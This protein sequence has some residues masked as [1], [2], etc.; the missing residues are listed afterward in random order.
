MKTTMITLALLAL[1]LFALPSCG[2]VE[3]GLDDETTE[4][5]ECLQTD[6][7][8]E[9]SGAADTTDDE[10]HG[11]PGEQ[12][13][14]TNDDDEETGGGVVIEE[15]ERAEGAYFLG[16]FS[17]MEFHTDYYDVADRCEYNF[18]LIVRGYLHGD[19]MDFETQAEDL[20][21]S[22]LIYPDETFDF[23]V[24][25]QNSLG[26]PTVE[27]TCTCTLEEGYNDYF[28]DEIHCGCE[29][30]ESDDLCLMYWREL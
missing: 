4:L 24:G 10:G 2:G 28:P 15:Y 22:A 3:V 7:C 5:I 8:G 25:F 29:S 9:E 12:G 23:S 21:F 30:N 20:A 1:G 14:G 18:P 27:V 16:T 11:S 19:T 17:S 26:Q 13:E 6:S